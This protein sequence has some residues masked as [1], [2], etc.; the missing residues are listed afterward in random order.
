[1]EDFDQSEAWII[2][3]APV[4]PNTKKPPVAKPCRPDA[5]GYATTHGGYRRANPVEIET[6]KKTRAANAAAAQKL[7]NERVAAA[8]GGEDSSASKLTGDASK[9]GASGE[10]KKGPGRP[11]GSKTK[12]ADAP[13]APPV[14]VPPPVEVPPAGDELSDEELARQAAGAPVS[15]VT[16]HSANVE[17]G[18]VNKA[19]SE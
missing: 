5:I 1:M 12:P 9:D 13:A 17:G 11:K 15:D 16:D 4:D 18:T 2:L 6:G 8:R 10:A 19:A 14:D 3:I 7:E